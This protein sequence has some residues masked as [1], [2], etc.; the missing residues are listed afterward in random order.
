[1]KANRGTFQVNLA[2]GNRKAV[3]AVRTVCS[4][5]ENMIKGV[6]LGFKF[7]MK[8]VYAHFPISVNIENDGKTV[9]LR[10]FLGER[11]VRTI[12]MRG[13]TIAKRGGQDNK[14]VV[15][16]GSDLDAVSQSAANIQQS[17]LVK[18]KDIRK[19]LDGVYVSEKG[20][21]LEEEE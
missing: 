19:F 6:T 11:I 14:D 20:T 1:M 16:E 7:N 2:Q 12:Q 3:A 13:D 5:V 15:V 21:I 4:H 18:N 10:N 9:E 8:L 17:C